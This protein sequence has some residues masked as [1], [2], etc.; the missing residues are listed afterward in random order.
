MQSATEARSAGFRTLAYT[1]AYIA[2]RSLTRKL[3][4]TDVWLL[5]PETRASERPWFETPFRETA[6]QFSPDG[7]WI[8]Y[9]SDESGTPDV[10]VRPYPGPGAKTKISPDSGSEPAWTRGGRELIYR[11]GHLSENFMAVDVQTTSGLTVSTPRQLFSSPLAIGGREDAFREYDVS[12]DGNEIFAVR[13]VRVEEPVRQLTLVTN[14]AASISRPAPP[15]ACSATTR[16][17]G[18]ASSPDAQRI[19]TPR[20]SPS[21][22]GSSVER[23]RP[24]CASSLLNSRIA[25][26]PALRPSTISPNANV[27][28]PITIPPTL[29]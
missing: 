20:L 24:P 7:K 23:K 29:R 15:S 27:L 21:P 8:A 26:A 25:S 9:V 22:V 28:S 3:L 10:Y 11:T 12:A 16:A 1:V 2:D 5:S 14:W 18:A 4:S 19:F 6:P 13:A 17:A